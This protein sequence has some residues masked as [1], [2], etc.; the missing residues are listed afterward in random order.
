M[1]AAKSVSANFAKRYKLTVSK[2]GGGTGTITSTPSGIACGSTCSHEYEEGT[3]VELHQ[4]ATAGTFK[5]WGGACSG[6]GACKVAMSAAK[7]VSARFV[8]SYELSVEGLGAGSGTIASTPAGISCGPSCEHPYEEGTEVELHA[9][10]SPGSAFLKWSGDC[11]GTGACKVTM[12]AAKSVSAK[13]VKEFKLTVSKSGAGQGTVSSTPT[14]IDCGSECEAQYEEATTIALAHSA[15]SGSEFTEWSGACTGTGT[16]KVKMSEAKAVDARFEPVP[17]P[18]YSLRIE[19]AGSGSGL[20]SCDGGACAATYLKGTEVNLSATA[21]PGSVFT[22]W[23]GGGCTGTAP[24]K[25]KIDSDTTI[26]AHF[27]ASPLVPPPPIEAQG[28][29]IAASSAVVQAGSASLRLSCPGPGK[30]AGTLELFAKLPP[31]A[32][33]HKRHRLK[34][35]TLIGTASFALS[36]GSTQ[37]LAV[38]IANSQAKQLLAQGRTLKAQLVGTGVQGR[39]VKLRGARGKRA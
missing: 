10:P 16:C 22:G 18:R 11:S 2:L 27:E 8:K 28:E 3:E 4:S 37:T 34:S 25:A 33:R 26:V 5:E 17:T 14:G 7:S 39:T 1:S 30:C 32:A 9:T 31:G 19:L 29:A 35:G 36:P 20:V 13:F 15:S 38:K 6:S 21:I 24:C 12:S 23:S